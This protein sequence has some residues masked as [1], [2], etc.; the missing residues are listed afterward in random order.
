[1]KKEANKS[2]SAWTKMDE[3]AIKETMDFNQ[4]YINFLNT[5][6]TERETVAYLISTARKAGFKDL[7]RVKKINPGDK[8]YFMD[9]HKIA[10]IMVIGKKSLTEGAN[11]VVSHIDTP[12]LDLK[13]RPMYEADHMALMKTHYYGGIKKYQ[14][15]GIPLA[16]HGVAVKKDGKTVNIV[17]GEKPEELCFT[18]TDLLPHLGK[19]QMEKKMSEAIKGEDL[20]IL[21]G[22]YPEP[23]TEKDPIKK[24]ILNILK[25]KYGIEEDDFVSAEIEA[26]PAFPAREIGLDRSMVGAY[27]QDD[28]VSAY[29]ACQA[30]LNAGITE[31][32]A[33]CLFVDKEEIGS[34]GNTGLQSLIMENL[35]VLILNKLGS[36]DYYSV[37]QG[38]QK[39][40]AIS[41]DVNAA[42]DPNYPSVF[43]KMNNSFLAHGVVLTKFTGSRGKVESNDSNPEFVARLRRLFDEH[44]V[45]WQVGELGSVDVGGGGTVAHYLARY[46]MEVIDCGVALLSMHSPFEIASKADIYMSNQAYKCFLEMEV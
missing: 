46:G 25:D 35:M 34:T 32:T 1:M 15:V 17:I 11:W 22:S 41:A 28:R 45:V 13:A 9:K 3:S 42:I 18:I 40:F 6:K 29:A 33:I 39:S 19:E 20:N 16:L 4:G 8:L 5:A 24:H 21:I 12:R 36:G 38:L 23:D 26:V 44:N 14:W 10:A 2:K 27:G 7:S 43:E 31:R 37:R 30:M